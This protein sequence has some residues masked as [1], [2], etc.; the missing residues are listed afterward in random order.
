MS[1]G[2]SILVPVSPGELIDKITILEIK[3]ERIADTSKH[4]NVKRELA[5]LADLLACQIPDSDALTQLIVQLTSVNATLWQIEDDI[6]LCERDQ[7]FGR[8]FIELA[9]SVYV[10]NDR[11]AQ[12]KREINELL[13]SELSEEKSYTDYAGGRIRPIPESE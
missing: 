2:N 3:R 13:V 11:R 7:T 4:E 6:R 8:R 5:L 12:L 9:R 1:H 10:N